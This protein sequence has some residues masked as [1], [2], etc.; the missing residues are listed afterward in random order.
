MSTQ[1]AVT[2]LRPLGSAARVGIAEGAC[3]LLIVSLFVQVAVYESANS[4]N[5]LLLYHLLL[6]VCFALTLSR[7]ICLILSPDSLFFVALTVTSLLGWTIYGVTIRG[8]LLPIAL[9]A[10][11]VGHQWQTLTTPATRGAVYRWLLAA[12]VGALLVRNLAYYDS[13]GV[14]YSR[15]RTDAPVF[16]L[17]SGGRNL[18]AT[19]LGMLA[20]L[21]I[22]SAAFYPAVLIAAVTSLLMLS[23]AGLIAVLVA[24][25][26]WL[27]HGKFGRFKLLCGTA[28]LAGG[29][30]AL[31]VSTYGIYEI[32][33]LDRFDLAQEQSLASDEQGRLAIWRGAATVIADQ[34]LGH[35]TGNGFQVVNQELGGHMRENNSH[36][37][38]LEYALDGGLQSVVLF[39][40]IMG[41]IL[42]IPGWIHHPCHRFALAYGLLGLVEYTGYD[43]IG[44]FFIGISHATRFGTAGTTKA[45][46]LR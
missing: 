44:W 24:C 31:L 14:I 40:L 38:L 3:L 7:R 27:V 42:R 45:E 36:N 32:P 41:S 6:P 37:I 19:Q 43:A 29:I 15:I 11:V 5:T 16:F 13:L 25:L 28:M 10:F 17:A 18:E 21:L 26:M 2:N 20:T 23:R 46:A 12:V 35:G 39:T 30:C 1:A 8:L 34:P 9:L 4:S 22:G 33:I